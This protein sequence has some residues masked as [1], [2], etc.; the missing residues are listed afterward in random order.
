MTVLHCIELQRIF[1]AHHSTHH[2]PRRHHLGG[3][4][5]SLVHLMAQPG[6][7]AH[8]EQTLSLFWLQ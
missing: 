6:N 5:N 3:T 7:V 2:K 4:R 1:T 8:N